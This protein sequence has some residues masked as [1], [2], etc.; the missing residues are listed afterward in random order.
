MASVYE[1]YPEFV[2]DQ[3]EYFDDLITETRDDYFWPAWQA[4]RA[5]EVAQLFKRV[6]PRT[7]L[8]LGCGCG[9]HDQ[10]MADY[11]FVEHIDAID[12]SEK[13]IAFANE[14][15][16]HPKVR[17]WVADI[18]ALKFERSYDL[19]VSFQ[20]FEHVDTPENY[21]LCAASAC[22]PGGTVAVLTPNR[23]R[24]QN[25]LRQWKG[26]PPAL[27]DN[28][29][30]KEYTASEIHDMGERVGLT[31]DG[32]FGYNMYGHPWV[33]RLSGPQKMKLGTWLKPIAHQIGVLMRKP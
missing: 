14:S 19:V 10:I 24:L 23:T 4:S 25:R 6:Q 28:Q 5:F 1:R 8:D 18:D 29:H 32:Y 20:V 2:S 13:S 22:A 9:A 15:F 17:R 3:R 21:L 33:D 11:L 30:F 31:P 12:Y 7:I 27:I 16:G 26:L